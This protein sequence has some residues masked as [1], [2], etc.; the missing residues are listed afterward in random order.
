MNNNFRNSAKLEVFHET[1]E[2]KIYE[3]KNS[4]I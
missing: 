1:E 3:T 2:P 4:I